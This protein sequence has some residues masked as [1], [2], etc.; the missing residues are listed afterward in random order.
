VLTAGSWPGP[1]GAAPGRPAAGQQAGRSQAG[2]KPVPVAVPAAV[3]AAVAS[4]LHLAPGDV[5]ALHDRD[6][7]ARVRLRITGIFRA[8]DPASL[9]W[10]LTP[11]GAGGS[12]TSG[13]FV[14]YGPLIVDPAAFSR[15]SLVVG[16]ASWLALPRTARIRAGDLAALAS[17][18]DR[19]DG[20]LVNNAQLGGLQV[21]TGL[22]GLLRG[23]AQNDVVAR[24]L[25]IIGELQ[26][27]LLA[28]AALALAASLL[29][30]QREG[31][32]ALLSARGGGRWQLAR[33][34]GTESAVL[35]VTTVAAG[36]LAGGWLAGRLARSGPLHAAGL[37]LA[38]APAIGW[39]AAGLVGLLC[40]A[41]LI[42]PAFRAATPGAARARV[43][44]PARAAGL[45]RAGADVALVVIAL[46][47]ISQLRRYQAVSRSTQGG[48]TIDP[49]LTAAPV[50]ALAAGTAVLLRLVPLMA[51]IG[52]RLAAR[53]RRLGAAMASWEISRRPVRQGASVLLVVLA[54][55]TSTLALAQHE[56]WRRSIADQAAFSVGADVRV[57]TLVAARP[58]LTARISRG[59]GVLGAMPVA[60]PAS[61]GSGQILALNAR[62]AAAT[63][64]L[65]PDLSDLSPAVLWRRLVPRATG[66]AVPGRPARLAVSARLS[67]SA[68]KSSPL[69]VTLDVMDATGVSYALPAG[70]LPA[71]GRVHRLAAVISPRRRAV[72][73]L[74]LTGISLA[75]TLA[76]TRT[77]N[78]ML[79]V[80]GIAA[81]NGTAGVFAAPFSSGRALS[82]W[83]IRISA[84][85]L[86]EAVEDALSPHEPPAGPQGVV[87][88]V[89]A[90]AGELLNFEPGYG[91]LG[92]GSGLPSPISGTLT[93][94]AP[95]L[96][97][98]TR[99]A[100]ARAAGAR[101]AAGGAAGAA[102]AAA[103]RAAGTIP[104]IATR[105]YLT[106][107]AVN[108]GGTLNL[109]FGAASVRVR[110][111]GAVTR[112]PTVS[113]EG[114]G[115][116]VDLAALQSV[117]NSENAGILPVSQW[118]LRT[119]QAAVPGNWPAGL[120]AGTAVESRT[121]ATAALLADPL[122]GL[123]QQA[124][125]AIALAAAA[126]AAVGFS[127]SVAAG[128]RERRAQRALLAAL[129][130]SRAAQARQLCLEQLLLSMPAAGAGLLLG[131]G[132][133]Q[134]L[135]QAVTLT[136]TAAAPVP[137]VLIEIPWVLAAGLA[138][139]VAVIPV[140][141]AA[142]TIARRPDPA[143]QLRAAESV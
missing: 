83:A 80:G 91:V 75:Y 109:T 42:W 129:G 22:P 141:A 24:S 121:A 93:L 16:G 17:R 76:A 12:T 72:Y 40:A 34:G 57:D 4:L 112:F 65:R 38:A 67:R 41:L 14:T 3:P 79:T 27:L 48:L 113:S 114:G 77:P 92:S 116:V 45:A 85:G 55:A 94:N 90:P 60:L 52:D 130:V 51:R 126:L 8:A 59:P 36:S 19:A 128:V 29:A 131:A 118:W 53:G 31:E 140:L 107:A 74:R 44:R 86:G 37:R 54:A 15:G 133:A 123:P 46:V 134:L 102:G 98:V 13:T 11:S 62:S 32:T 1:P 105:A 10:R 111:V 143:A 135:V 49:V 142:L 96:T 2:G 139:A 101:G 82:R 43:G 124:L 104:A 110:I 122:S 69:Q 47:A 63:V 7:G 125:P 5:L 87:D 103:A 26:L 137:T 70:P 117:L 23:V 66:L 120:P 28:V 138:V 61:N 39:L 106:A 58:D 25:L 115:L 9:Y 88:F 56:S 81:A 136:A 64:L 132:L 73:P 33:L 127:V 95:P 78:A 30:S 89:T 119:R 71:D 20:A 18:V 50:L 68:G 84:P 100:G 97:G 108:V 35:A 99:A 6:T 21:S